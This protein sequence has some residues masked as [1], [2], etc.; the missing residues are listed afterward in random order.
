L[1]YAADSTEA[2]F[3]RGETAAV[4]E[5]I[6]WISRVLTLP[7]FWS[8]RPQWEDLHQEIVRRV[9]ESLRRGRFQPGRDLRTYVQGIARFAAIDALRL[10]RETARGEPPSPTAAGLAAPGTG[11]AESRMAARQL[12]RRVLE[13]AGE[14]CSHLLRAYFYHGRTYAEIA[15]QLEIP[16]G[17]VKSRLFRC[18]RAVR[19]EL[20]DEN[21]SPEAS[22][23]DGREPEGEPGEE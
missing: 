17:T 9:L 23:P 14:E 12:A 20:R 13:V 1:G 7:R 5:V 4:G 3:L 21:P 16:V 19:R 8:L 15:R 11:D 18:M 10:A 6:R 22:D 2:R